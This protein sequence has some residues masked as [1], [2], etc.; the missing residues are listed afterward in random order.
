[1]RSGNVR[2]SSTPD[3]EKPGLVHGI[4]ADVA[5]AL[6]DIRR[7]LS[8]ASHRRHGTRVEQLLTHEQRV[9]ERRLRE[10]NQRVL[11]LTD[12]AEHLRNSAGD[13]ERVVLE[14]LEPEEVS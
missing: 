5:L 12:L 1:M 2:R 4:R 13:L 10:L 6:Y 11:R 3:S 8:A 14:A 9:I 7:Y